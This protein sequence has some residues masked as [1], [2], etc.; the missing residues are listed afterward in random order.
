MATRAV[1]K[2]PVTSK[3]IVECTL[4]KA[5]L[6]A[7]KTV[8]G[9]DAPYDVIQLRFAESAGQV[10]ISAMNPRATFYVRL[11]A[12]IL[13]V[14][15]DRDEL[16]E[17]PKAEV[18]ALVHMP[19][20]KVEAGEEVRVG[21]NVSEEAIRVTDE[22]GF[23][24]G[25]HPHNSSFPRLLDKTPLG[26]AVRAVDTAKDDATELGTRPVLPLYPQLDAIV[27]VHRSFGGRARITQVGDLNEGAGR[28]LAHGINWS[29]TVT[30]S[31][32]AKLETDKNADE[33]MA[34]PTEISFNGGDTRPGVKVA[35]TSPTKGIS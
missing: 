35:K 2:M 6:K 8:A 29:M 4:W 26:D 17:F 5:A 10:I 32:E 16:V 30:A 13:G 23:G 20:A 14:V 31:G 27:K 25:F 22:S 34:A 11:D 18:D 33:S 3:A 9:K 1:D 28:I 7:A 19:F 21:I 12:E 15:A 24:M